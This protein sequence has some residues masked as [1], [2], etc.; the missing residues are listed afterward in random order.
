MTET[1]TDNKQPSGLTNANLCC[2]MGSGLVIY[3][4]FLVHPAIGF[5]SSGCL[6]VAYGV[7]KQR[8]ACSK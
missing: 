1:K 4:T 2:L 5:V 7:H 6:L 3:G 8:A